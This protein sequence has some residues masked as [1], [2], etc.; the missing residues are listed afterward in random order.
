MLIFLLI[1]CNVVTIFTPYR[2]E[3]SKIEELIV[4]FVAA[5]S[6]LIDDLALRS[7]S[8]TVAKLAQDY[9]YMTSIEK[10]NLMNPIIE[11]LLSLMSVSCACV[12]VCA[13]RAS[14]TVR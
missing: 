8:I 7:L 12:R 14:C 1:C 11:L 9:T 2:S 6:R 4:K 13:R 5:G 10:L 3:N